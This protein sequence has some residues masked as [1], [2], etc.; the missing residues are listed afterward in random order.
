V[1]N[2]FSLG[3]KSSAG[4]RLRVILLVA[5]GALGAAACGS[6]GSS[7]STL[8]DVATTAG[9]QT[10]VTE[11]TS[12]T[13]SKATTS[14][15][16]EGEGNEARL[17]GIRQLVEATGVVCTGWRILDGPATRASCT[18]LITFSVLE[19]ESQVQESVDESNNAASYLGHKAAH[20]VGPDWS[21]HCKETALFTD[22]EEACQ[23]FQSVLGGEFVAATL[24]E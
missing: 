15:A 21:V 20:V 8:A 5:V 14:A 12:T 9:S 16:E 11:A 4:S 19:D 10:T 7:E 1:R 23:E 18:P 2:G 3:W 22:F 6:A 13:V 24:D 17:Q